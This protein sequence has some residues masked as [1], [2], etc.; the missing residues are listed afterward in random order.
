MKKFTV[1][2]F[3]VTA[4]TFAQQPQSF[5]EL[6]SSE[7]EISTAVSKG[8]IVINPTRG[9]V[10]T[11]NNRVNWRSDYNANCN[12]ALLTEEDFIGSPAGVTTCGP[13]IN[14]AGD[15]CFAAGEIVD[16]M[17]VQASDVNSNVVAVTPDIIGNTITVVGA[18]VFV[19]FTIL[20]FSV[21]V[22]AVG[23]NIWNNSDP[24]TEYR[25][26]DANGEL[27]TFFILNNT[28]GAEN[29][30]GFIADEPISRIE[31]EEANDGS[32]LFGWLEFG[33]CFSLSVEDN[34]VDLINIYPN[35]ATTHI[36]V[37]FPAGM[38]ILDI[39]LYDI[40]G[41][42]TGAGLVNGIIDVS[43]ISR[44]VY[45]LHV[46]TDQGTLTQKVIKR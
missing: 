21:D 40:L 12:G 10:A 45:I 1:L 46:K 26:F 6:S 3:L 14:S 9:G 19:D 18:N 29:F 36:N 28:V 20:N 2:F 16:G 30:F 7:I 37:D 8:T 33:D 31:I 32:E 4:F 25:I 44:G 17:D 15:A 34:L 13:I 43:N 39:T 41:K 42:N 24:V 22:Y 5:A 27:L 35:P 38:D 23:M 11:Y